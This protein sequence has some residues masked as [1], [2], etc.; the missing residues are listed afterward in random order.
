ME[1]TAPKKERPRPIELGESAHPKSAADALN[2]VRPE[3]PFDT[4]NAE[5]LSQGLDGRDLASA[6]HA[7]GYHP[8][9]VFGNA[10]SGKTLM[11]LSLLAL[12]KTESR[13]KIGLHLGDPLLDTATPSGEAAWARAEELFGRQTALFIEG[14]LPPAT[15][16]RE[17]FFLPLLVSPSSEPVDTKIAFLESNGEWYAPDFDTGRLFQPLRKQIDQFIM[18]FEGA[19][20]FLHVL[21]RTQIENSHG[22]YADD[23]QAIKRA[24]LAIVGALQQYAKLRS[25]KSQDMHLLLVTKWD[26]HADTDMGRSPEEV[27][28]ESDGEVVDFV[29]RYCNQSYAALTGLRLRPEQVRMSAYCSARIVDKQKVMLPKRVTLLLQSYHAHLWNWLYR[30]ASGGINLFPPQPTSLI[31]RIIG[32]ITGR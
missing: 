30:N 5:S 27:L 18:H 11:L 8:V 15:A 6:L 17:P 9:I 19:I 25:D 3:D 31:D 32:W 26:A 28:L 14:T 21:P 23:I 1:P 10:N 2:E 24:D 4:K 29:S 7:A 20:S 16:V 22:G 12:I 13:L